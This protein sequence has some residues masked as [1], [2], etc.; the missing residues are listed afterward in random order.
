M[1]DYTNRVRKDT[2]GATTEYV[3]FGGQPIAEKNVSTGDWSDY[4]YANGRVAHVTAPSSMPSTP[5][6]WGAPHVR[7]R[8]GFYPPAAAGRSPHLGGNM[9]LIATGPGSP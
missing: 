3:Y 2:G 5:S 8:V 9:R 4:I 1:W 6:P 7:A